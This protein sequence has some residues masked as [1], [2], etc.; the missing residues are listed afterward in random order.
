MLE[1]AEVRMTDQELKRLHDLSPKVSKQCALL[2][3]YPIQE[4]LVQPDFNTN[5]RLFDPVSQQMTLIDVGEIA[6]T[7]PFFS[8]HNFLLQAT[9]GGKSGYVSK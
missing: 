6:I 4:T 9:I 1:S 3:Q 5:N 2:A 7:H 8:L